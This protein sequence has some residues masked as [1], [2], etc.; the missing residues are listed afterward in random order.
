M[1]ILDSGTPRKVPEGK[2]TFVNCEVTETRNELMKH[3]S[4]RM[5]INSTK[6]DLKTDQE[7]ISMLCNKKF[8]REIS[9]A[10]NSM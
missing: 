7:L 8:K 6:K 10:I 9:R 3:V 2:I 4:F 1:L 5:K